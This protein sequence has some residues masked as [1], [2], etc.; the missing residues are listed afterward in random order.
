M[1][2]IISLEN[3]ILRGVP[4]QF[5]EL[6]INDF[7]DF[8]DIKLNLVKDKIREY[9]LNLDSNIIN[10]VGLY[11]F[12]SNGIGK[13]FIANIL[14]KESYRRRFT[15]KRCTFVE[16]ISQYTKVWGMKGDEKEEAEAYFYHEYKGVELLALDELGKELDVGNSEKVS[17]T[18][19]EDCLRYR[20]E[21]GLP[22]IICSNFSPKEASEKYGSS[23]SSLMKGNLI[24]IEIVGKDNRE[25]FFKERG[26]NNVE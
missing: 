17:K 4:K 24:P 5:Y 6:T 16:Y 18:I 21:K 12:G 25:Y 15:S 13:S 3:L 22:I 19:L 7:D 9:I 26:K 2:D 20:E 23:I 14:V 11:L 8:K 10:N 1:R